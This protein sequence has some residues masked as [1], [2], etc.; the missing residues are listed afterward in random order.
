MP[1]YGSICAKIRILSTK[2]PVSNTKTP[3]AAVCRAGG[4]IKCLKIINLSAD[5]NDGKWGAAAFFY[6]FIIAHGK[7]YPGNQPNAAAATRGA[8]T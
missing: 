5:F 3:G 6:L 8:L 7:S 1:P 4:T 2:M